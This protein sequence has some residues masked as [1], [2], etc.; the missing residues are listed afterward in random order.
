MEKCSDGQ[1]LQSCAARSQF[2]CECGI[3]REYCQ[4][5]EFKISDLT[6]Y[7]LIGTFLQSCEQKNYFIC[8]CKKKGP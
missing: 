7:C 4:Y 3:E 1:R 5:E 8:E 6:P 2:I